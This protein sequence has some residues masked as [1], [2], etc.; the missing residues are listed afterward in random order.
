ML[1]DERLQTI[2]GTKVHDQA[3]AAMRKHGHG[4]ECWS[5]IDGTLVIYDESDPPHWFPKDTDEDG[6]TPE[7]A[8][9]HT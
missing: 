7:F 8:A 6:H 9:A 5:I 2:L 1:P 4:S 3:L